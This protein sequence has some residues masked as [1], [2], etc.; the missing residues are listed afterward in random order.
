[1]KNRTAA[2]KAKITKK[3]AARASASPPKESEQFPIVGVGASAGGLEAF[4]QLLAPMSLTTGMAFVLVPHLAPK[5]ESMLTELLSK[6]TKLP[7]VQI[8]NG[9]RVSPNRVHIIPPNA[10]MRIANGVLE[11]IPF[12]GS[13]TH[14]MPIDQFFR[15]LAEDQQS[16]AIGVILSG[17]ASDGTL[18]LQAIKAHGGITFAQDE[19]TA[20]YNAM[21]RNA[22]AS[23]HVDFVLPPELIA[24]E[25]DRIAKHLPALHV[26]EPA[27]ESESPL[28][29]SLH[30]VFAILKKM[31]RVDF[32]F[33]KRGT[34]ERRIRRRM[35]LRKAETLEDY[36]RL[37]RKESEE[38]AALFH[39]V[40]I[41]VTGFF[42]DPQLFDVL[43]HEV[44]PSLAGAKGDKEEGSPFRIW[45][46]GCSTGEEAYSLAIALMEYLGEAAVNIEVQI[47]ATDVSDEI[48]QRA[49]AGIYPENITLDIDSERLRRF[50]QKVEGGYQVSKAIRDVVVFARQDL[51]RDPPF[52]KIDLISCRNV[53][54][55]MGQVL[56]KRIIPLFHYALNPGGILVLGSSETVGS[57]GDLFS[58]VDK[59]FKVY[60]KKHAA[61]PLHFE[62]VP[63][64]HEEKTPQ[65]E[66]PPQVKAGADLQRIA[67]QMLLNRYAPASVVVNS[68]LDIVMFLGN[69]GPFLEPAP[70]D[71][72]LNLLKMVKPGLHV[73]LRRAFQKVRRNGGIRRE[74][75]LIQYDGGFRNINFEI[76]SMRHAGVKG[77]FYMVVFED[78]NSKTDS[79]KANPSKRLKGRQPAKQARATA[80]REVNELK[81]ELKATRE[82]LQAI[83]EE[84]RTANEESRS[85]NEEIQSSNE[86]LQSIN[87]E[88]ETAKEELQSANEELTTVNE[89]L[90]NRNDELTLLNNDLN[91]LLSS[92]NIPIVMLSDDLRIR[93]FTPMAEKVMN[94]I[95]GDLGRPITDIKPNIKLGDLKQSILNVIDTLRIEETEVEDRD[96][97]RYAMTIRPYRTTDNKIEGVVIVLLDQQRRV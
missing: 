63:Q 36:I 18:G 1:M 28:D 54:I 67:D 46:P 48:V 27:I 13:K 79:S 17:T 70:G 14:R 43:K 69:T 3:K 89:E 65:N 53:M 60:S 77:Q 55:Y 31:T 87:E 62:F 80:D 73:E 92:V 94:L 88:L 32:G 9:M 25:L 45:V 10:E 74:G 19:K 59:K 91:N 49:R 38:V 8:E 2:K 76:N 44:F 81:E 96:G 12:N 16:H 95:P 6:K 84:Q 47:F 52:S 41:N 30:A 61:G 51:T 64:Y 34:L 22:V 40:L 5:H 4:E 66:P 23:G 90:Q 78:A 11:L 7:V 35:F 72:S 33:Y 68:D 15:S 20:K 58:V 21:P 26:E 29:Q 37:L 86:E 24:T 56:Q 83:I 85:A 71:A 93:R 97:K 39:D 57:F 75:L 42:R 82:Y 50:F